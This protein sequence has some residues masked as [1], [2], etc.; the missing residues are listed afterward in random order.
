MVRLGR[1][2]T[3]PLSSASARS[4][5]TR[6]SRG[7]TVRLDWTEYAPLCNTISSIGVTNC[8]PVHY[9]PVFRLTVSTLTVKGED[10]SLRLALTN[11]AA[12]PLSF[13]GPFELC[14]L[15]Q[16][17]TVRTEC[18]AASD[19]S[20]RPAKL[21]PRATW[22]ATEQ[23]RGHIVTGRWLRVLLPGVTGSFSSP[24]GGV[25]AWLTVH[26]YLF[27][28]GGHSVARYNGNG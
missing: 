22:Q 1:A 12:T 6:H 16:L 18:T 20:P 4:A 5:R 23:G 8:G 25:I 14:Q 15:T 19:S 13:S 21:A 2:P 9:P 17:T 10:W 7:S 24:T 27:E 28:P 26:A 3:K 11:L